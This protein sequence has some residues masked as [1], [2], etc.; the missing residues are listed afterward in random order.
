MSKKE[1]IKR[2]SNYEV[3]LSS[4]AFEAQGFFFEGRDAHALVVFRDQEDELELMNSFNLEG[5]QEWLE[6]W[7][8][9]SGNLILKILTIKMMT[10]PMRMM[11]MKKQF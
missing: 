8:K 2:K 5:V 1:K 10:L 9:K 7:T 3:L 4:D 6:R 11:R